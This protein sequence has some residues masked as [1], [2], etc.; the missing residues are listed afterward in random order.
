LTSAP[1]R[2]ALERSI[3]DRRDQT[4][5]SSGLATASALVRTIAIGLR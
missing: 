2:T 4:N 1:H 3:D 5:H